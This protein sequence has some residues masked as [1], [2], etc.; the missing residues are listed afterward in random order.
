[1][2]VSNNNNNNNNGSFQYLMCFEVY[3]VRPGVCLFSM[4]ISC[5][6]IEKRRE[7]TNRKEVNSITNAVIPDLFLHS[8]S[9]MSCRCCLLASR[10]K[11]RSVGIL[12]SWAC[13]GKQARDITWAGSTSGWCHPLLHYLISHR[14]E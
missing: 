6:G 9:A 14:G 3:F 1:M 4:W 12:C 8:S 2:N 11:G 5:C 10:E 7:E 13:W